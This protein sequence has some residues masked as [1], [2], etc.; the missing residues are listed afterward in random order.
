LTYETASVRG[1][2]MPEKIQNG[3]KKVI[4]SVKIEFVL[5]EEVA[6]E[7]L[8]SAA[9][10]EHRS[11]KKQAKVFLL[12][13][14]ADAGLGTKNQGSASKDDR[15]PPEGRIIPMPEPLQPG[16]PR[17]DDYDPLR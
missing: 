4:G 17:Y 11:T 5:G 15:L 16:D 13:A 8:Q 3:P 1:K 10:A 12:K 9:E 14:L 6:L 2:A 7:Q